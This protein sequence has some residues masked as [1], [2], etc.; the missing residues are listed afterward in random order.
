MG[1][2]EMALT[3]KIAR[4]QITYGCEQNM[5]PP[6][7]RCGQRSQIGQ[8]LHSWLSQETCGGLGTRLPFQTNFEL[9]CKKRARPLPAPRFRVFPV[10]TKND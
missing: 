1:A 4:T 5:F 8:Q 9:V 7:Y 6:K 10:A 2:S 3:R